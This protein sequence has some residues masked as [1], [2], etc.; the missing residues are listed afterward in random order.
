MY[1]TSK[2]FG[3]LYTFFEDEERMKYY[4]QTAAHGDLTAMKE[5]AYFLRYGKGIEQD[6]RESFKWYLRAA[7]FN[8]VD[9]ILNV[10]EMYA[11]GIATTQDILK[12]LELYKKIANSNLSE[13]INR[14]YS[15]KKIAYIYEKIFSDGAMTIKWLKK[16]ALLGDSDARFKIAEIYRDGK[17]VES[18]PVR[19]FSLS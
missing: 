6:L 15:A 9:A 4:R 2:G 16:S 17:L 14:K 13:K 8:D 19:F 3:T 12:A 18:S 5:L 7:S 10:A 1:S 11:E